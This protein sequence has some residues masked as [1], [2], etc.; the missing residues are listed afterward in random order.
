MEPKG[1]HGDHPG[2]NE[3]RAGSNNEIDVTASVGEHHECERHED[4]ADGYLEDIH[5]VRSQSAMNH[6]AV[7]RKRQVPECKFK[8]G[9]YLRALPVLREPMPQQ[10]PFHRR[11]LTMHNWEAKHYV[12]AAVII[13]VVMGMFAYSWS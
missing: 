9:A 5:G 8:A 1:E 12:V 6:S 4:A 10:P 11:V 7:A 13:L 3:N 2:K